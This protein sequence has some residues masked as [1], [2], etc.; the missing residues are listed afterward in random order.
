[1]D[2]TI[3]H[4][5][6]LTGISAF[7]LRNWEKRYEFLRPDRMENGFRAYG[8]QH[9]DILRKV[10]VLLRHGA[11]IGDLA[12]T[13]RKGRPLP[14]VKTVELSPEVQEQAQLLYAALVNYD[15]DR[16]DSIHSELAARF[17]TQQMLDLVY[18]PLLS[19]LGKD[20]SVGETSTA[21]EHFASAFI[22]LRLAPYL[23][24]QISPTASPNRKVIAATTTGELH[25]GGLM[26]VTAHLKLRG[27]T[28]YYFGSS[29][30]IEDIQAAAHAIRPDLVCLSFSDKNVLRSALPQISAIQAPICIGGFGA[31]T[32]EGDDLPSNI[33]VLKS[34][35]KEGVELI[36]ALMLEQNPRL[37]E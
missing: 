22:R 13:I 5:A 25:E 1:M 29:L 2:Y 16:A 24:M 8:D 26:L 6:R 20:W 21:Q 15:S 27:W 10:A 32:Y 4:V 37:S 9:V 34:G 30:P 36:E 7:T 12:E 28:T 33:Q 31:L 11:K 19:R 17:S 14:E 18:A 3:D 35:G 23:T